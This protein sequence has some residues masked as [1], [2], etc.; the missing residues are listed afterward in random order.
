[1]AAPTDTLPPEVAEVQAEDEL[2]D[3]LIDHTAHLGRHSGS[4]LRRI[5]SGRVQVKLQGLKQDLQP[6]LTPAC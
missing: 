3:I 1:M 4:P 5:A 2:I 6:Q